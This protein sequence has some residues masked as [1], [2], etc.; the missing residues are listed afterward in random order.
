[1]FLKFKNTKKLLDEEFVSIVEEVTKDT[2]A[3]LSEKVDDYLDVATDNWLKEN[4]VAV[5]SSLK[6]ELT[7]EFI[8]GL[9]NLFM[10]HYIDVPEEKMN[11]VESQADEISAL[12][13]KLNEQIEANINLNK[14]LLESKKKDKISE[15]TDK[16]TDVQVAKFKELAEGV[17]FSGNMEEYTTKL[18]T[19]KESFFNAKAKVSADASDENRGVES[20]GV[21]VEDVTE[22]K[23]PMSSY[24]K[25]LSKSS[26]L[27]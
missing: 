1:M 10:E 12:E 15:M 22:V 21:L 18:E 20:G 7:E 5:E 9:R 4:E 6:T 19:I 16:L 23:G 27:K 14:T 8:S 25:A 2:V 11:V 3:T 17:A 24:L 26:L 13:A